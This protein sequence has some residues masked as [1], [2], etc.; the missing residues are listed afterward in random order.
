MLEAGMALML[1]D[2]IYPPRPIFQINLEKGLKKMGAVKR[3]TAQLKIL[4]MLK[5]FK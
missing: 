5:G 4:A 1:D 3:T 2:A